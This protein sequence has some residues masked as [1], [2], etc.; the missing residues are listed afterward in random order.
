MQIG[1]VLNRFQDALTSV[2][3]EGENVEASSG[4]KN[5]ISDSLLSPGNIFE[6]TV[7]ANNNG[8]VIIKLQNGGTLRAML[9]SGVSIKTGESLFFEVKNTASSS[10]QVQLK[11]YQGEGTNNHTIFSA[12]KSAGIGVNQSTIAMVESMMDNSMPIDKDSISAMAHQIMTFEDTNPK[13]IVDMIK[14]GIPL[15]ET[16][17]SQ[18]ENYRTDQ[19]AVTTQMQDMMD[20]LPK[21]LAGESLTKE[22]AASV[23]LDIIETFKDTGESIPASEN[24]PSLAKILGNDA[25]NVNAANPEIPSMPPG[26][27]IDEFGNVIVNTIDNPASSLEEAQTMVSPEKV[28]SLITDDGDLATDNSILSVLE[29]SEEGVVYQKGTDT[30]LFS[31]ELLT[32]EKEQIIMQLESDYVTYDALKSPVSSIVSES[33][34][35][36][37]ENTLLGLTDFYPEIAAMFEEG[38]L[39][40]NISGSQL[41]NAIEQVLMNPQS[42]S[43]EQMKELLGDNAFTAVLKDIMQKQWTLLPKEVGE[44]KKIENLYEKL[45]R[46]M[47]RFA[48][49]FNKVDSPDT[50]TLAKAA[51]DVRQNISFL[52]QINQQ[53]SYVQI[54]LRMM[55][56]NAHSDLYVYTN[57][58]NMGDTDG[59]LTAFLH[60]DMDHLGSTD[61]KVTMKGEDVGTH[62]YLEDEKAFD[63]IEQH[64]DILTERLKNKGYNV[65]VT[66]ENK[67][68]QVDFVNDFLK[69]GQN[70][71][72]VHRYSFDVTV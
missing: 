26:T 67:E 61:V 35:S 46:Q 38:S 3:S 37:L 28:A 5:S 4:A 32:S 72:K 16:N 36:S 54:P 50:K 33:Q 25:L 51:G 6:G 2:F 55:G 69:Q 57:K 21:L 63:F 13:T 66:A 65:N 9:D 17:I 71:G 15:N 24:H 60:L 58:K 62:F 18:F 12:L 40:A 31:S 49:A 7:S 52:N 43:P 48:E 19:H 11:L 10:N 20:S 70:V 30:A 1:D 56:Q 14:I 27:K 41:M 39:K 47:E 45:D 8:N 22:Q 59:T 44:E 53:Y 29:D 68:E 23:A 42:I 34:F 64:L